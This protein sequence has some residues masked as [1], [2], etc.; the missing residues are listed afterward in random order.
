METAELVISDSSCFGRLWPSQWSF[1]LFLFIHPSPAVMETLQYCWARQRKRCVANVKPGN[2]PTQLDDTPAFNYSIHNLL[3][4]KLDSN[5]KTTT[6]PGLP[7]YS[8]N[9]RDRQSRS[10]PKNPIATQQSN[11]KL[12]SYESS[13]Q[14]PWRPT[15]RRE[16]ASSSRLH[17]LEKY[18]RF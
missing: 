6:E 1:W 16:S 8:A 7:R 2:Q 12:S 5:T 9:N 14:P 11:H 17:T 15:G 3:P 13:P 18:I 4:E 10:V